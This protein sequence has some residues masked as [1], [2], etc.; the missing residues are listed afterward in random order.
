VPPV[1]GLVLTG[2]ASRR[3]GI[4]KATLRVAGESLA[5]RT[6]RVLG[7]VA[8]PVLEVGPGYAAPDPVREP[9]PGR[10]PL[11]ALVAGAAALA[12]RGVG[13]R[14]V[15]VVA[16][17]L[18]GLDPA[19][20]TLLAAAPPADVVVPRVAGRD[21]V[22]CARYSPA[23]LARAAGLVDAGERSVRSLLGAG[24]VLR[25]DEADW[26]AVTTGACFVDVDTPEDAHAVGLEAPG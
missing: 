3:L 25:L 12:A 2:G 17:D 11:V 14:A 18:P 4:P 16:V 26:G 20:L 7:T 22:L 15:L 24:S 9:E 6:V 1:A 13:D 19:L 5:G 10:G 21:Q 23:A 8:D